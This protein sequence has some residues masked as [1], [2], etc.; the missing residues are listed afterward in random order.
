MILQ[1]PISAAMTAAVEPASVTDLAASPQS[2]AMS[3]NAS[4]NLEAQLC[5][6]LY[7]AT[8]QI[9]RAYRAPLAALGLT[10]PQYLAMLVLW[11]QGAQTV[12]GLADRLALDS[13]TLTPLL[14]RLEAAG[15]VDR[16]RND[17]DERVVRVS[18][19]PKG[20]ALQQPVAEVQRRVACK[21]R[22]S[23]VDFTKLRAQLKD[24]ALVLAGGQ[25]EWADVP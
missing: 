5:F 12:K 11:E 21:T 24:L 17:A 18:L 9:V 1:P 20:R 8:N 15:L 3:N 10:Y 25:E 23:D 16:A 6:A 13:S 7:A 19:T 22:L 2:P 4:L 14:K